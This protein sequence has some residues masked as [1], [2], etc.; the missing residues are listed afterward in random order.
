MS[1]IGLA[2]LNAYIQTPASIHF[3]KRMKEELGSLG[4]ALD[5]KTN[6]EILSYITSSGDL[7]AK[8]ME[9]YDLID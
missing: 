2:I 4:V 6:A 9:K 3:Y 1:K 5:Y 8:E 7:F